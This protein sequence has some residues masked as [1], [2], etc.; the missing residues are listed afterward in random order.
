MTSPA[1]PTSA[2]NLVSSYLGR[3]TN[4]THLNKPEISLTTFSFSTSISSHLPCLYTSQVQPLQTIFTAFLLGKPRT[5]HS[6]HR[7]IETLSVHP[8]ISSLL[9]GQKIFLKPEEWNTLGFKFSSESQFLFENSPKCLPRTI[10]L[11]TSL[12]MS[13]IT[14]PL[15]LCLSLYS[16]FVVDDDD[17]FVLKTCFS[18]CQGICA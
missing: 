8:L 12:T 14:F 11:P 17:C 6:H 13:G 7:K 4:L 2:P 10:N 1:S 18:L 9:W 5:L 15:N 16:G 3:G